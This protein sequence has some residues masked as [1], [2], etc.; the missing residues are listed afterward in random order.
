M[1]SPLRTKWSILV[2]VIG[3][4]GFSSE[5]AMAQLFGNR[6]L[7]QPLQPAQP[8][9]GSGSVEAQPNN[10]FANNGFPP[11]GFPQPQP[12]PQAGNNTGAGIR[13]SERFLR[14]SRTPSA[15]VGSDRRDHL[16]GLWGANKRSERTSPRRHRIS[17]RTGLSKGT[18]NPPIPALSKKG[19]Y[20][21]RLELDE[22]EEELP[23]PTLPKS[24]S[25][26][27]A[28][29]QER[30]KEL[31]QST[32]SLTIEG[33]EAI[34]RGRA[35]NQEARRTTG[36]P[37]IVR[38]RDRSRPQRTTSGVDLRQFANSN[39]A[40]LHRC[41]FGFQTKVTFGRRTV[42][43]TRDLNSI[44]PQSHF[45]IHGP[46]VVAIPFRGRLAMV[47]TRKTSDCHRVP[48]VEMAFIL[49]PPTGKTS[50]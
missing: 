19:M 41:S 5:S 30:V 44:D 11:F 35:A 2:L 33:S 4:I 1:T 12:A 20:Y 36:D 27:H 42:F 48:P 10:F 7:G 18:H 3:M 17:A 40:K 22:A 43:A 14:N 6:S 45:A 21:P 39:I 25:L 37:G 29:L 28:K 31:T 16:V 8:L 23:S 32:A 46:H 34:L 26:R 49:E 9:R 38:T 47:G 50:P 15:F 13:G 24:I